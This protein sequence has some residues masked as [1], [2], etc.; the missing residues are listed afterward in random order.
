MIDCYYWKHIFVAIRNKDTF[1]FIAMKQP[2]KKNEL[3]EK[4]Q[5][6]IISLQGFRTPS[7]AQR[8][9]FG[10]GVI[11][12]AFPNSTFPTGAVHEFISTAS[13]DAASTTGFMTGLLSGLMRKGGLCLW[14]SSK[15]T[16]FP[17]ALKIFGIEPEKVIFI[18]LT[19]QK[20]LIW[21]IEEALK[22]DAL[23][24]VVGELTEISFTESRRLQ[25]AVEK[26]RV[27][28]FLHRCNPRIINT[29]ACVSRWKISPIP[30][31]LEEGMPGI[32]F[33]RWNVDLLKVRNGEPG[34]WQ[35]EWAAGGFQH[36]T[37]QAVVEPAVHLLQTG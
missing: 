21:A 23:A 17:P 35:L 27:T 31:E 32:G 25:L 7:G 13:E 6:E 12:D 1:L 19:K 29:L 36:C 10:L 5:K 20:D 30:S 28:G 22:C 2:A 8:I 4:L 37:K 3:V 26:S 9:D 14:I 34:T 16:V 15:R 33:P 24:A 11:E 18:N